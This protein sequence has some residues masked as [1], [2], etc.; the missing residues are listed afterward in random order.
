MLMCRG[1]IRVYMYMFVCVRH[2][3]VP[4]IYT[5]IYVCLI[6]LCVQDESVLC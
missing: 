4:W 5:R 3:D 6:S 2:V 1:F